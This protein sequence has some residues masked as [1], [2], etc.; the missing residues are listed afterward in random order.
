MDLQTLNTLKV[1]DRIRI[2]RDDKDVGVRAGDLGTVTAIAR[3]PAAPAFPTVYIQL[4]SSHPDL[5][6]WD[7]ELMLSPECYCDFTATGQGIDSSVDSDS[8]VASMEKTDVRR[9]AADEQRLRWLSGK[10]AA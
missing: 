5:R 7:N 1:G 6:A 3:R 8:I 10:E 9:T 2:T 4:D